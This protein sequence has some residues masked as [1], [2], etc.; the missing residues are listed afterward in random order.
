MCIC[1]L[2]I[3]VIL[4]NARCNNKDTDEM[5]FV[6]PYLCE[7]DTVTNLEFDEKGETDEEELSQAG[8]EHDGTAEQ[9]Q[10]TPTSAEYKFKNKIFRGTLKPPRYQPEA[11]S[12]VLMK[13]LVVYAF[14]RIFFWLSRWTWDTTKLRLWCKFCF[15][16]G[17][18]ICATEFAYIVKCGYI[19]STV[20]FS[21]KCVMSF[22]L[23]TTLA[24]V[25]VFFGN[26]NKCFW[27]RLH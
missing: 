2:I 26:F 3:K 11:P 16:P 15:S 13:Y 27:V 5:L 17:V 9:E 20:S 8:S 23:F 24:A 12:A 14:I 1:W 19:L 4:Q 6:R 7:R 22:L 18:R 21:I 25:C 10:Q